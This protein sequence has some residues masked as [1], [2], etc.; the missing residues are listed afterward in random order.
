MA[1][2]AGASSLLEVRGCIE[3]LVHALDVVG[4]VIFAGKGPLV[5]L[6]A[7]HWAAILLG[8]VQAVSLLFVTSEDGLGGEGLV[9]AAL[10]A[11]DVGLEV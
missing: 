11:A 6:A 4:H 9:V 3:V 5:A 2:F 1:D 10:V 7:K 8:G